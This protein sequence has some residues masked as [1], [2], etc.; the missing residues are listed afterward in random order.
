MEKRMWRAREKSDA[1]C[2]GLVD[3]QRNRK[4]APETRGDRNTMIDTM[5]HYRNLTLKH[6]LMIS[7]K[8]RCCDVSAAMK[9][10]TAARR[11][12]STTEFNRRIN[13]II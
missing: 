6:T 12:S 1:F 13:L 8:V 2:Q 9:R 5:C 4:E 7:S 10:Q 3:E 11:T